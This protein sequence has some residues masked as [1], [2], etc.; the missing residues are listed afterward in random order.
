MNIIMIKYLLVFVLILSATSCSKYS[1]PANNEEQLLNFSLKDQNGTTHRL[2]DLAKQKAIV[3]I[4]QTNDCPINQKYSNT[5]NELQDKFSPKGVSFFYLNSSLNDDKDS[6]KEEIKN[7]NFMLPVLIDPSQSIAKIF[8]ITRSSEAIIILPKTWNIVYR[9]AI[10]DRLDYGADKQAARSNYLN[11]AIENV[12]IQKFDQIKSAPTKGCL[13]TFNDEKYTL[14]EH[15][16][17]VISKNCI[18]CHGANSSVS[19]A[20]NNLISTNK[21]KI[22]KIL[23]L[24]HEINGNNYNINLK[25]TEKNIILS[26]VLDSFNQQQELKI[27]TIK[28]DK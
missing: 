23:L 19:L 5:V 24:D 14:S 9:G 26:W 8:S 1:T 28:H 15:V 12:L 2:Y 21:D 7:Y 27:N 11:D 16:M 3:I 6:I 13:F 10:S 18:G 22:R 25:P 17:P 20:N 4:S